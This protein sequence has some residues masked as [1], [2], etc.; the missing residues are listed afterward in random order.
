ML[1]IFHVLLK[2]NYVYICINSTCYSKAGGANSGTSLAE[3]AVRAIGIFQCGNKKEGTQ[4][5]V[6]EIKKG[7]CLDCLLGQEH[8]T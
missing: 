6:S 1:P 3:I 8:F 7:K 5:K 4:P 2:L